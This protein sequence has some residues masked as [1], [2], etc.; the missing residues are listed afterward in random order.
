MNAIL[1]IMPHAPRE[2]LYVDPLLPAWLPDLTLLDLRVGRHRF[3]IRFWRDGDQ[4][5]FEVLKGD[6]KAVV[7][8]SFGVHF[9]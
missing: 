6:P 4:T 2:K 3:D 9:V 8:S 7:E 1:G 5:R